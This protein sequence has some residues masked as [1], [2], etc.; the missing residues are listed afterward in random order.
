[1]TTTGINLQ[2]IVNFSVSGSAFAVSLAA[3]LV[4]TRRARIMFEQL[5]VQKTQIAGLERTRSLQELRGVIYGLE[6]IRGA[7]ETVLA[8]EG[9]ERVLSDS[10]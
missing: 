8:L 5:K 4:Q 7:I 6:D 2:A 9:N 1:M 3:L 10:L